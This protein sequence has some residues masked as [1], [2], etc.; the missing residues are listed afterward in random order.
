MKHKLVPD[1]SSLRL[2]IGNIANAAPAADGSKNSTSNQ[3][4]MDTSYSTPPSFTPSSS[5]TLLN[6]TSSASALGS[7]SEMDFGSLMSLSSITSSG[8]NASM[9]NTYSG[10]NEM[11]ESIG[12]LM[13]FAS[14]WTP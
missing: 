12:T 6:N 2:H 4:M 11:F 14:L 10:H 5:T 13:L 7:S 8:S 1:Q 3:S 9:I